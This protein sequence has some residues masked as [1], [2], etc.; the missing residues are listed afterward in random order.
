WG[1]GCAG[2]GKGRGMGKGEDAED[3]EQPPG[4]GRG[5]GA[6]VFGAP[7]LLTRATGVVRI[8]SAG[9]VYL[10]GSDRDRGGEGALAKPYI[11]SVNIKTGKKTRV[12]EGTGEMLETVVA[13]DGDDIRP[14]FT[15]R[16]KTDEP[17]NTYV[18]ELATGKST[19]LTNNVNR[20]PWFNKL[21]VE[22][23]RVTRVDGFKFWVKV[24]TPP[25]ASGKLPALF[26]IY[27]REYTD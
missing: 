5:P 10:S 9:E 21:K 23:F 7:M 15:T 17:P 13:V 4:A 24:T 14:V 6:G 27:P 3:D 19:K 22:R 8:S 26:W 16:Q 2:P 11:D 20:T 12:F 1:G 18:T 25:N